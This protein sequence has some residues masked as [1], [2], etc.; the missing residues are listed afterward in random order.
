MAGTTQVC[1]DIGLIPDDDFDEENEEFC[2]TLQYS[3]SQLDFYTCSDSCD[4]C[5]TIKEPP[6][7]TSM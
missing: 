4:I 7:T 3:A 6:T 1:A 5:V 2:V